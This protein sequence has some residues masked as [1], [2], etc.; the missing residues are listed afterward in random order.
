ME[1]MSPVCCIAEDA[2]RVAPSYRHAG[3]IV[4]GRAEVIL[5]FSC[6]YVAVLATH[7]NSLHQIDGF[8]HLRRIS[9]RSKII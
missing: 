3:W 6:L 5:R 9:G 2:T 4:E 1:V 8:F 7:G